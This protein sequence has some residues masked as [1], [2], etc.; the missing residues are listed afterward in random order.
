MEIPA[1]IRT[2]LIPGIKAWT[3]RTI[4][5]AST[6]IC[7]N[8]GRCSYNAIRKLISAPG[9]QSAPLQ[10]RVGKFESKHRGGSFQSQKILKH[11][12]FFQDRDNHKLF[13]RL[14]KN[15]ISSPHYRILFCIHTH[16]QTLFNII[17]IIE[18]MAPKQYLVGVIHI[19]HKLSIFSLL[20]IDPYRDDTP[21]LGS[22]CNIVSFG[23]CNGVA[24][25]EQ[26]QPISYLLCR[27]FVRIV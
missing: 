25:N 17:V 3:W 2:L 14:S 22:T 10:S 15:M 12:V 23:L 19:I 16:A 5:I 18:Q 27:L 11:N 6:I 24:R 20:E 4:I 1:I 13:P 26:A 8:L 21:G 7:F 9:A